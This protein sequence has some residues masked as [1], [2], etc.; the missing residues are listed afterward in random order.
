[1]RNLFSVTY[2]LCDTKQ[3]WKLR[4]W[5]KTITYYLLALSILQKMC[6]EQEDLIN[7]CGKSVVYG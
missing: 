7:L 2:V 1:M 4:D 5:F 6:L 3:T